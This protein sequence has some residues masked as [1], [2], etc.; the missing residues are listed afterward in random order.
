M[1]ICLALVLFFCFFAVLAATLL[2]SAT[3]PLDA[4]KSYT[5]DLHRCSRRHRRNMQQLIAESLNTDLILTYECWIACCMFKKC[6]KIFSVSSSGEHECLTVHRNPSNSSW[7]ISKKM[8]DKKCQP[9]KAKKWINKKYLGITEVIKIHLGTM[10]MCTLSKW[11]SIQHLTQYLFLN[12]TF[13]P[14]GSAGGKARRM[15]QSL[16]F[17]FWAPWMAP[18]IQ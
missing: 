18:I 15:P 7:T 2:Q 9:H 12:Y 14:R 5:L 8:S 1:T 17:I 16:G 6:W 13:P 11:K 3:S 4:T 10:N